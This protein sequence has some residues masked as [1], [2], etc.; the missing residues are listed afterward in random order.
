[1]SYRSSIILLKDTDSI[2]SYSPLISK[3]VELSHEEAS[4]DILIL[5]RISTL[6]VLD[7]NLAEI[8]S[9]ATEILET[10][11]KT[12]IN[13]R[14]LFNDHY[15]Q[16]TEPN[17]ESIILDTSDESFQEFKF[18]DKELL[19][20]INVQRA[21]NE[22]HKLKLESD[23]SEAAS[24][25][26]VA[27]GG[28]FDHFHDGHK[29]LLSAS[30][31]LTEKKLIVGI[32]DEELLANKKYKEFLQ[33]YKYREHVLLEFLQYIKPGIVV[34][35]IPIHDVCGPTGYI[36]EIDSLVVSRETIKGGDFVNKT[37]KDK[38]FRELKIHV[39]NV[40]G[41]EEDDG[42]QNKLS[43]TQLRKEEYEATR[44]NKE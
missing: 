9:L 27:V 30:A 23:A 4:I 16:I 18:P 6:N 40:I 11:G 12:Q 24:D 3:A 14:A 31:F 33:S 29:I 32:T 43:S 21:A 38:G 37:R 41:G 42:F 22:P 26:V 34:D 17:W 44:I 5:Q 19:E 15:L 36:E 39:I 1:M 35:P 2:Q 25:E 28:T 13:V 10:L 20:T 7:I 8:Y